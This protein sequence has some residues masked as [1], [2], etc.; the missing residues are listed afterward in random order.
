MASLDAPVRGRGAERQPFGGR[1]PARTLAGV[2]VAP[3]QC[4]GGE[5]RRTPAQPHQPQADADRGGRDL[6]PQGRADPAADPRGERQRR[7]A[8]VGAARHLAGA[9]AHAGRASVHR[10]GAARLHEAVSRH[11][12]RPDA[13]E[14]RRR[15][16]R[17]EYRHRYPHRQAGRLFADRP[18]AR[19]ERAHRVCDAEISARSRADPRPR[20]D[21]AQLP[22]LP[23]QSRRTTWRSRSRTAR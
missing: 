18:Q 11:H 5:R 3:H 4:A 22:D 6:F 9:F 16:G 17:A 21:G 23:A 7:A 19:F 15:P 13:L 20:P 14:S 2:G 10:A 12:R 8:A 1:T